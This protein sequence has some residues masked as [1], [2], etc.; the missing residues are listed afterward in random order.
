MGK[1]ALARALADHQAKAIGR[2]HPDEPAQAQSRRAI[3]P[4]QERGAGA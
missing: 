4:R 1:V 2:M 3:D